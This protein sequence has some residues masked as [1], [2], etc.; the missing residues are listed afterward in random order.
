M[1]HSVLIEPQNSVV[2]GCQ[3]SAP[4][5]IIPVML[6]LWSIITHLPLMSPGKDETRQAYLAH[7]VPVF[8]NT[9]VVLLLLI[10]FSLIRTGMLRGRH[11]FIIAVSVV[12]MFATSNMK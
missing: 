5:N 10:L 4:L 3:L 9:C 8:I 6:S 11:G 2:D 12:T 7:R 1:Q